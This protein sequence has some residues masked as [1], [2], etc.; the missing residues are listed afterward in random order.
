VYIITPS[1]APDRPSSYHPSLESSIGSFRCR[2]HVDKREFTSVALSRLLS[3]HSVYTI[4]YSTIPTMSSSN[5]YKSPNGNGF[6]GSTNRASTPTSFTGLLARS[7]ALRANE[8]NQ[9]VGSHSELPQINYGIGE[10][11]RQSEIVAGKGKRK[12]VRGEGQAIRQ[13]TMKQSTNQ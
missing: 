7:A 2:G 3:D 11:E 6:G 13:H 9:D 5:L 4:H 12:A 1:P 10:I 8:S